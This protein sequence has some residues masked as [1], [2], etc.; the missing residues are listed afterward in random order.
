MQNK[1]IV[2]NFSTG[3]IEV[4]S[5]ES[6]VAIYGT[7]VGL[8]KLVSLL[9]DLIENPKQGHKHLEDY[10]ILTSNSSPLVI[11]IFEK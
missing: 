7:N 11:A 10:D 2:P 5:L 4:R 6:E 9:N 1:F 3:E 8:T